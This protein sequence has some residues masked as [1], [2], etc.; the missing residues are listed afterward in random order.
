[1][2][3]T[4]RYLFDLD[5]D[6]ELR[7]V[8]EEEAEPTISLYEHEGLM[9]AL[10]RKVREQAHE[11]GR[12]EALDQGAMALAEETQRLTGVVTTLLNTVDAEISQ[13]EQTAI[14]IAV[15]TAKKLASRLI[16]REPIGEVEELFRQALSPM[17]DTSH[18]VI[19]MHEAHLGEVRNRLEEI[20]EKQGFE[21]RLVFMADPEFAPG[22]ARVEWADGGIHRRQIE[23]EAG[24]D[25][26]LV[27][28]LGDPPTNNEPA[29]GER[30]T[31]APKPSE[32][33]RTGEVSQ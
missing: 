3:A 6:A 23:I 2:A 11:E 18:L 17:L 26:L 29:P 7:S 13:R 33:K 14:R 10:E 4:S 20:A 15:S 22:D 27:D 12:K 25:A 8:Q 9:A 21:G 5:F 19:R 30:D 32:I 28:Y 31:D 1:M 16:A 24:I